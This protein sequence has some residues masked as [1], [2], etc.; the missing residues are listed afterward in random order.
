MNARPSLT[1]G[2]N[3]PDAVQR[4]TRPHQR[5]LARTLPELIALGTVVAGL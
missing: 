1:A 2:A 3:V 5:R 4:K